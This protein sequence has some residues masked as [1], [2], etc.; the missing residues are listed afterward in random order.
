MYVAFGGGV[1]RKGDIALED[2]C[3]DENDEEVDIAVE[4]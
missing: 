4:K 1:R 2:E 3:I